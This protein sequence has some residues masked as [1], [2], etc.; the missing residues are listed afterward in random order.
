[1]KNANL[2]PKVSVTEASLLKRVQVFL[3]DGEFDRA[4]EYCERVLD[5]NV[6]NGE[7]YLYKLLATLRLTSRHKLSELEEPFDGE[8]VYTKI[9]RFGSAEL[10]KEV[11]DINASIIARKAE[12]EKNADFEKA[13]QLSQSDSIASLA[14]AYRIFTALSDFEG[15]KEKAEECK[16]DIERIY[17]DNYN[18]LFMLAKEK[19][20]AINDLKYQNDT[21]LAERENYDQYIKEHQGKKLFDYSVLVAAFVCIVCI[22]LAVINANNFFLAAGVTFKTVVRCIITR[23]L[24]AFPITWVSTVL[25]FA[26]SKKIVKR[27]KKNLIE[28][29]GTAASRA[30]EIGD[31]VGRAESETLMLQ[32]ELDEVLEELRKLNAEYDV[33]LEEKEKENGTQA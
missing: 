24:P 2:T 7:A 19:E 14:E 6:E 18:S 21:D 1:M 32:K 20:Q 26:I 31:K 17:D 29:I 30:R 8:P 4:D 12:A 25:S 28:D 23:I 5:M 16:A 15:A 33:F 27:Q 22:I 11:A 9:M 10:K 13:L 3:E